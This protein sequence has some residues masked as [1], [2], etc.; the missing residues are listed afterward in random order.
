MKDIICNSLENGDEEVEQQHVCDEQVNGH[1][2]SHQALRILELVVR[3][4][5]PV[6]GLCPVL[7]VTE[8]FHQVRSY[9]S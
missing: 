3:M 5:G 2:H 9:L 1:D 7:C 6:N 8:S 4:R